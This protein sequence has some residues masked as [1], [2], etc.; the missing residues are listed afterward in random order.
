VKGDSGGRMAI[1]DLLIVLLTLIV[2]VVALWDS[3]RRWGGSR[4][5]RTQR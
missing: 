5:S 1:W 2:A 4:R 3:D